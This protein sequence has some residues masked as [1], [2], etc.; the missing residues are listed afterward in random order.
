[1]GL[2]REKKLFF[3]H[4][5]RDLEVGRQLSGDVRDPGF[6]LSPLVF[7]MCFRPLF[8]NVAAGAPAIV[9]IHA[10]PMAEGKWAPRVSFSQ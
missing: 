7:V 1:M 8:H 6:L 3:F 10:R 4:V 5:I 9:A 2:K